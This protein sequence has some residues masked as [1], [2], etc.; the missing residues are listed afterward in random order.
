MDMLH[1]MK[2]LQQDLLKQNKR[3]NRLHIYDKILNFYSEGMGIPKGRMIHIYGHPDCGKTT[4]AINMIRENQ[5]LTFLYISK[6]LDDIAKMR[7]YPNVVVLNSSTFEETIEFI[8]QI[9]KKSVDVVIIDNFSNMISKEEL[10]SAFTKR[11]DNREVLEKYLKKISA[12]AASKIFC[13]VVLNG[14]N[15]VTGK[16][17][18]SYLLDRESVASFFVEKKS[19]NER[20]VNLTIT[21]VR[22]ILSKEKKPMEATYKIK[23]Y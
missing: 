4:I 12:L 11:L 3:K 21:P 19:L 20:H 9:D 1:S 23:W 8:S 17:R 2:L 5:D 14:V 15:L 6:N 13:T 18:Y 7:Y 16:S 22:N 10:T